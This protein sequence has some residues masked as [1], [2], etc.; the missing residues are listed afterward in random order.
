MAEWK[1]KLEQVQT[2]PRTQISTL[3]W[4]VD[5]GGPLRL[6]GGLNKLGDQHAHR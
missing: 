3:A 5:L 6:L 4:A 1:R 2:G